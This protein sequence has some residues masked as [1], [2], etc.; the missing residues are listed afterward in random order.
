MSAANAAIQKK[1]YGSRTTALIISNED[2]E[3]IMKIIKSLEESGWLVKGIN[4]TIKNK[5]KEKKRRISSNAVRST[6]CYYVRKCINMKR[7]NKSR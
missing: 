3:D 1:T 2:M 7:S 5:T 6:S 4:K